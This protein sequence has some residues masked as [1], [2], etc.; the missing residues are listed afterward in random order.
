MW[1]YPDPIFQ[2]GHRIQKSGLGTKLQ[3]RITGN[4]SSKNIFVVCVNHKTRNIRFSFTAQLASCFT[5]DGASA[6]PAGD[7]QQTFSVSDI[8][9]TV[10]AY[11]VPWFSFARDFF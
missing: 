10:H 7:S 4:F 5:L 6:L 1:K 2:Q 9:A 11:N 3:C 8:T